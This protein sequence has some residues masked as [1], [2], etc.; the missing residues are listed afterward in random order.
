MGLKIAQVVNGT[1]ITSVVGRG[2]L[3]Q[4]GQYSGILPLAFCEGE[5]QN[6][7]ETCKK[8]VESKY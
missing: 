8:I 4:Y 2:Y 6:C 7:E 3:V 5:L 1:Y